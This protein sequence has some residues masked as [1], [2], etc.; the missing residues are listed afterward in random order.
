MHSAL[1]AFVPPPGLSDSR[2]E[3]SAAALESARQGRAQAMA[4][5][6]RNAMAQSQ[7]AEK[8]IA[9]L[10]QDLAKAEQR[11]GLQTLTAPTAGI[12]QELAIHSE[13]DCIRDKA[14]IGV[15]DAY[16]TVRRKRSNNPR[17]DQCCRVGAFG[18]AW[19]REITGGSDFNI[20]KCCD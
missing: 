20:R 17:R 19:G 9:T 11:A 1:V 18:L 3:Q 7:E 13:G 12:V 6:L 15:C 2:V 5:F 16:P 8:K 4:D 14:V 10:T